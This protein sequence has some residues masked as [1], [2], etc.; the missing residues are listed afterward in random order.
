MRTSVHLH[1]LETI[2]LKGRSWLGWQTLVW[3]GLVALLLYS[4]G[5]GNHTLWGYHEPYVGGIIRE[6]VSNHDFVVPTLNGKPYLEKPPLFYALGA[7]VCKAFGTFEPWALRLP[8]A[9]LA[10]ATSVWVSFMAWR[11]SSARAAG[12]AGFT[13]ATSFLFFEVGH[14]AVVDMTLTAAVTFALG[15]AYLGIVEP[16]Y[17]NRWLPW[18]W[19]ALGFTFMAKGVVGP[20]MVMAP[21]SLTLILQRDKFLLRAFLRR[22][23]GMPLALVLVAGWVAL[24]W[25]RGGTLFLSEVFL[26]NTVGRFTQDPNLVPAT[27]SLGEH[28]EPWY[29]YLLNTP[30]NVLPWFAVW[31]AALWSAIPRHRHQHLSPRTYFLPLAFACNLAILSFS[32]AKREVYLLPVLPLTFLHL[33]LW[34]DLRV[35]KARR[36]MDVTLLLVLA[37]TLGLAGLVAASFPWVLLK[38][39]GFSIGYAI[40]I[41]LISL[42]LSAWSVRLLWRREYPRAFGITMIQWTLF[43]SHLLAFGVPAIDRHEWRPLVDPYHHA[44]ALRDAGAS[45]A[46]AGLSETQLGHASLTLREVLPVVNRLNQLR[47]LLAQATPVAVLVEPHWWERAQAEGIKATVV[48][49]AASSLPPNRSRRAPVLVINPALESRLQKMSSTIP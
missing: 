2:K 11:L 17:R 35:P 19:V 7:L 42:S 15:L 8:S 40:A 21:L 3:T 26:R 16:A 13:L 44:L 29:F 32:Q 23:W 48:A 24:L 34:L 6:M 38:E 28:V 18:F 37:I 33:A 45:L 12:W 14:T 22:N 27:G 10:M 36:R 47:E 4:L 31:I 46:C 41:S 43:L 25:H 39:E 5:I 1:D 49:T 20:L 9:L 30:V